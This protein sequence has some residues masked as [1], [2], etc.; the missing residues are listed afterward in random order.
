MINLAKIR[1]SKRR[2]RLAIFQL[3]KITTAAIFKF[4]QKLHEQIFTKFC[5]AVEVVDVITCD[6]FSA[7][8]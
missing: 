7:I 8:G 1:Q 4:A 3:F 5:T 2:Y 6:K